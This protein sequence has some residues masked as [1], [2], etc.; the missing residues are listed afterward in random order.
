MFLNQDNYNNSRYE[1]A[2]DTSHPL[3]IKYLYM[4]FLSEHK[5]KAFIFRN[6]KDLEMYNELFHNLDYSYTDI[7]DPE[8]SNDGD[9]P[10][11]YSIHGWKPAERGRQQNPIPNQESENGSQG[12]REILLGYPS[13]QPKTNKEKIYYMPTLDFSSMTF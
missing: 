9:I 3:G 11:E 8:K 12:N 2:N 1:K 6:H 13:P 4:L 7:T 10:V 5:A